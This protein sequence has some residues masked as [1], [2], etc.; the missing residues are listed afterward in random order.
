MNAKRTQDHSHPA[1]HC[2]PPP[3]HTRHT[4]T[5]R[6]TGEGEREIE[7]GGEREREMGL[8]KGTRGDHRNKHDEE[9]AVACYRVV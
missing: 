5:V 9:S 8:D 6:E 4:N 1:T 3:A 7:G 2:L